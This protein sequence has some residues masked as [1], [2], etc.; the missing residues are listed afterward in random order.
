M[1]RSTICAGSAASG[2]IAFRQA[3]YRRERGHKLGAFPSEE[4]HHENDMMHS[5]SRIRRAAIL[6][7]SEQ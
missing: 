2:S 6:G 5:M 1:E 7:D 3:T 4:E